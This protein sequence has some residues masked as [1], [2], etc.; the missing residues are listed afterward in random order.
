MFEANIAGVACKVDVN[1]LKPE[2]LA[3]VIEYG[4]RQYLQDGAAASLKDKDG[5]VKTDEALAAEKADGVRQRLQNIVDG[6]FVRRNA[7]AAKATPEERERASYIQEVIRGAAKAVGKKMPKVD[8]EAYQ[9]IAKAYY[10][11]NKAAVDKEVA[12]RLRSHV[13][14]D[15]AAELVAGL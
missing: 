6:T 14:Q 1:G 15:D 4:L 3:F 12:R 11:K 10:E 8:S 9:G 5:N 7:G 13:G 2:S